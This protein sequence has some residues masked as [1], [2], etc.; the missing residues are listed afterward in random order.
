MK[1]IYITCLLAL[2]CSVFGA[3]LIQP[4]PP[5]KMIRLKIANPF[6]LAKH[7]KMVHIWNTCRGCAIIN[8]DKW[9]ME[10]TETLALLDDGVAE[11]SECEFYHTLW[12]RNGK[13]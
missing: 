5:V 13:P 12:Y 6:E 9:S 4:H 7:L 10:P 3:N 11:D 2:L 1:E 8:A